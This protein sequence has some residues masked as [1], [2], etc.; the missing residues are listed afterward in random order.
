[1]E[2]R[3]IISVLLAL[4][5]VGG[6]S[7]V[8]WYQNSSGSMITSAATLKDEVMITNQ[9]E[10][11][12]AVENLSNLSMQSADVKSNKFEVLKIEGGNF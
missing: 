5:L 12:Q 2:K 11:E 3:I 8:L 1:M 7:T 9:D 10:A 4:I 6:M